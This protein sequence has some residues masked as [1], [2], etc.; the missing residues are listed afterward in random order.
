MLVFVSDLDVVAPGVDPSCVA[1][2]RSAA[3]LGIERVEAFLGTPFAKPFRIVI[4]RDRATFDAELAARWKLP[5]T[6]K[7]MV[8][9]GGADALVVLSPDR[10]KAE[11]VEHDGNSKRELEEIVAHELSHVYHAQRCPKPDFDGMDDMGWFIE[12]LA[13]VVS[14]QLESAHRT[15]AKRAKEADK[16]PTKLA[17]CWSGPF[18]YGVSGSLVRYVEAWKGKATIVRLLSA[19]SNAEAMAILGITEDALLRDWAGSIG[20]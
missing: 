5:P 19:T 16:L 11:A 7:W 15:A 10:W 12:G 4:A 9:A 17:D 6:E 18:R 2:V 20:P 14:G 3:K 8:G 13:V 1:R